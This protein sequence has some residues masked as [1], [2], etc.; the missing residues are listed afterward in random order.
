MKVLK[1]VEEVT[2]DINAGKL[3]MLAGD[4]A[5]MSKL[6]KGTWIGGT[7]PYFMDSDG[8]VITKDKIMVTELPDVTTLK[9]IKT[10]GPDELETISDGYP[11]NGV[12]YIIIPVFSEVHGLFAKDVMMYPGI[13]NS[14]LVGWCAGLH[15]DDFATRKPKIY[16]GMTGESHEDRGVVMHCDLPENLYAQVET[17]NIFEDEG[18]VIEFPGGS[19]TVTDCTVNGET[20]N[21]AKYITDKGWNTQF[22]VIGDFMGAKL[23]VA[24]QSVDVDAG[25]VNLYAPVFD[26][27]EYRLAKPLENYQ[28]TFTDKF[29]K[30]LDLKPAFSCNCVLN[31]LY[32][33]LE[34]KK[35]GEIT[36]PMTFGEIAYILLNQTMV[37][38]T[39]EEK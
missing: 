5:V 36:G 34:G 12:S 18:D 8:G 19:T 31:F 21:F 11:E 17:I 39:Y 32:G 27:V 2:A 20:V 35:T 37:Y 10:Y 22:P 6:P 25:E 26:S 16:D 9:S 1:S 3:L 38:A 23:V 14:P 30:I 29:D 24:F 28:K 33:D 7:I 13:F 15:L 4:D